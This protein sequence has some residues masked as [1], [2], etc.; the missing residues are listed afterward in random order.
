[1]NDDF[2]ERI[3][4]C[5]LAYAKLGWRV[6]P[7]CYP[8]EGKC[9]CGRGNKCDEKPGK[10]PHYTLAPNGSKDATADENI[11]TGWFDS[12]A[13][14]FN[15]GI[16]AG[17]ESGLVILD[18]DPEHGGFESLK[19]YKVPDTLSVETGS[20][21]KH[22]YFKH[23]GTEVRNSAG[24]LGDGL[25][26]RGTN[27]Y[28]VAPC[29]LHNSGKE[30]KWLLDPRVQEKLAVCPN[31]IA[32]EQNKKA[33]QKKKTPPDG[34]IPKTR[35]NATLTSIAGSMR[36]QGC[37]EDEIRVAL[38]A[39]NQRRCK[40][41]LDES[42]IDTISQSVSKYKPDP[43]K[44]KTPDNAVVLP[45]LKVNTI[46]AAFEEAAK[47][48]HHYHI[49]D[50]WTIFE[51]EQHKQVNGKVQVRKH[52]SDFA[53]RC[54]ILDKDNNVTAWKPSD[55]KLNSAMT[56]LSFLD[57]VY[58]GPSF[59]APCS[60]DGEL[61]G[62]YLVSCK[63]CLVDIITRETFPH[64]RN[65]YTL[66]N[67]PFDYDPTKTSELW[68]DFLVIVS[69]ED[70]DLVV[71]LLQWCGYCL[72]PT[73]REQK[74]LLCTGTGANGKG[75][76]FRVM[77]YVLGSDNI[78]SVSLA[79][80]NNRNSLATTWGKMVNMSTEADDYISKQAESN[81][82]AY[83]GED[84]MEFKRLYQ[85]PFHAYPTAKLMISCNELPKFRDRTT[86]IDRRILLIPFERT[87]LP[88]E[89]NPKLSEQLRDEASGIFNSF[90]DGLE[91][92]LA[93]GFVIP[94][95]VQQAR[96]QYALDRIPAQRFLVDNYM[97]GDEE[98]ILSKAEVYQ[99]Y[100]IW[101]KNNGHSKVLNS[102]NFGKFVLKIFPQVKADKKMCDIDGQRTNAYQCLA[103]QAES[104]VE[105]IEKENIHSGGKLPF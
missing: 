89:I 65:Y 40:P 78:S 66:S 19:K 16:A 43:K 105:N 38:S 98:D 33:S 10:A 3:R 21:G 74:F 55:V 101:C 35:R 27:G 75:T 11:I 9:T 7:L 26:V 52:L 90:L 95:R 82:K 84:K 60:L 45:D 17:K 6:L 30:Y 69:C 24:K 57:S 4:E 36:K 22:Y 86:A 97:V 87:F 1:M 29:S 32:S 34:N 23:P 8:K 62:R 81:L 50:G 103:V 79:N 93:S 39:I 25:D 72:L 51:S 49:R 99:T 92:Y 88:S 77:D 94:E 58:L 18:V 61:A 76:F 104:E 42:E 48:K 71:L 46:A 5:A 54:I 80:L 41:P 83:T 47:V 70:G 64:N 12:S 37:T 15:I 63:N 85:D 28:V 53:N 56:Q 59:Q 2:R 68:R 100:C 91:S 73:L 13:D 102:R 20:G 67:L 44:I 96:S 31:W 14:L